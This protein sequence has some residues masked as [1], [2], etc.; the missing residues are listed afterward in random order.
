M[1][2]QPTPIRSQYT[3]A[4]AV[5]MVLAVGAYLCAVDYLIGRLMTVEP[6]I[7]AYLGIQDSALFYVLIASLFCIKIA[8]LL[9]FG[10]GCVVADV[11]EICLYDLLTLLLGLLLLVAGQSTMPAKVLNYGFFVVLVARL[12]W[13]FKA[14]DGE[15]AATWPV[16]GLL[17][18]FSRKREPRPAM[19]PWHDY[20][21]YAVILISPLFG[22]ALTKIS[23][24][25]FG[26]VVAATA[27]VFL[28]LRAP[29][30]MSGTNP[31]EPAP[32]PRTKTATAPQ[33]PHVQP[34]TEPELALDSTERALVLAFRGLEAQNKPAILKAVIALAKAFDTVKADQ[35]AAG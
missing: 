29:F 20:A 13:H 28:I 22:L 26:S 24:D 15:S 1:N 23:S 25:E 8:G 10:K 12:C 34:A 7:R 16:F 2:S 14:A 9:R 31:A 18:L 11:M 5:N 33:A 35:S 30:L 19:L 3:Q 21:A 17:G 6:A 27:V 32:K 4:E